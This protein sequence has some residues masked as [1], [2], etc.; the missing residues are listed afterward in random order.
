MDIRLMETCDDELLRKATHVHVVA[1]PGFFLTSLGQPFL[2]LLYAGFMEQADGICLIAEENGA[3]VGFAMGTT[4]PGSFFRRLLR[5]RGLSFAWAVVP[6]LLRNPLLVV[7]KCAGA[8]LYRGEK[9]K[10]IPSAALLSSLA[11]T[12]AFAGRG[13]GQALVQRFAAEA[14]KQGCQSVYLTTDGV[15]NEHVNRFYA[16]CGFELLD[17]FER[18]R[19]RLMNRWVLRA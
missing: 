9:P 7:R 19:E 17:S 15:N 8:V 18:P 13:I 14:R 4:D 3:V 1:F 16:K 11:V 10:G 2:R 6:P 5:R 12:P